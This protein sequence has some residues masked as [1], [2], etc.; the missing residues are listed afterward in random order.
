M[1]GFVGRPYTRASDD[2]LVPTGHF[3]VHPC[4]C[5]DGRFRPSSERSEPQPSA[6]KT[7]FVMLSVVEASLLKAHAG[8]SIPQQAV[9][10]MAKK[11]SSAPRTS[12]KGKR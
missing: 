7:H 9:R 6:A 2:A 11:R 5:R 3:G 1:W 10:E 12:K 8:R 4:L